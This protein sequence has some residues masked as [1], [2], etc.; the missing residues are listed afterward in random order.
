MNNI[1]GSEVFMMEGV[2]Y[3]CYFDNFEEFNIRVIEFFD[4]LNQLIRSKGRGGGGV[5]IIYGGY[6]E[7]M[8]VVYFI[9]GFGIIKW[10]VQYLDLR[11]GVFFYLFQGCF[12][13]GFFQGIQDVNFNIFSY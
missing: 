4:K 10:F 3:L 13:I 5:C 11:G 9:Q 6:I 1:F 2:G 12:G 7:G 8:F